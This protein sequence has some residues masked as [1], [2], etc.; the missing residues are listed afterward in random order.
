MPKKSNTS[1]YKVI[2]YNTT[3]NYELNDKNITLHM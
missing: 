3:L 2:Q 1:Q